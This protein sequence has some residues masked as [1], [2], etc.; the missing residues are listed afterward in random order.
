MLGGLTLL[1]L[2][3]CGDQGIYDQPPVISPPADTKTANFEK[4]L[5]K[6]VNAERAKH[7]LSSL[8]HKLSLAKI[9]RKHSQFL[10]LNKDKVGGDRNKL[11]HYN[12]PMRVREARALGHGA[13]GE[14]VLAGWGHQSESYSA[15]TVR[16]W[17]NS[18]DH[19]EA[20]LSKAYNSIG[21]GCAFD[22]EAGFYA[23]GLLA[24]E[25]YEVIDTI[26]TF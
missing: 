5:L 10:V 7:G 22:K 24:G 16:G 25:G 2:A 4:N 19:R 11:A 17:M 26:R 8:S 18:K 12:F 20:I 21:I 1:L 23:S 15:A 9:A 3:S 14:V 6:K 13:V